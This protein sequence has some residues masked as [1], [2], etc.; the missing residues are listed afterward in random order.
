MNGTSI[1]FCIVI[2]AF[3]VQ[4]ISKLINLWNVRMYSHSHP[5]AKRARFHSYHRPFET[6]LLFSIILK[7]QF[8][9]ML[10]AVHHSA[11]TK[12]IASIIINWL[13]KMRC[14]ILCTLFGV[15]L[16]IMII[17]IWGHVVYITWNGMLTYDETKMIIVA[18]LQW[19]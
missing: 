6:K 11:A 12:C 9:N 5:L 13:I 17:I 15:L 10:F 18:I 2:H 4:I 1:L 3:N 19:A 8:T 7:F 14:G 16:I